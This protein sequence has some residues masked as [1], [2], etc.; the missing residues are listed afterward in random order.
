[1]RPA[2]CLLVLGSVWALLGGVAPAAELDDYV[3]RDD[4]SFAW[5]ASPARETAQGKVT[6]IDLTSQ[7]W[8][9]IVWKHPLRVYEAP[10]P[11]N[12]DAMIL[13]ITGGSTGR[14]PSAE[15]E[16]TGLALSRMSGAR[17]A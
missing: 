2:R 4:P 6:E 15:E 8:Q 7:T 12:R 5:K 3:R 11:L 10:V 9:G 13:F 16:A 17:V 14:K 1:M